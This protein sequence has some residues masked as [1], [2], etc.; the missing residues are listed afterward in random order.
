TEF[1]DKLYLMQYRRIQYWIEWQAKKHGMIV[2]YVNP[3][4]SSVSC[5]KC[6]HKMVEIAYRYFHCPSCGYENDRDVIAVMNLNGR[7]SLTLSTAPQMRDVIPN[8]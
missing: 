8:R 5:P 7:G 3:R 1:H 6:G 4:Y 2:E